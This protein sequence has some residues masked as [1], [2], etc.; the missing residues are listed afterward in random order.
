[1][2][3]ARL[4]ALSAAVALAPRLLT[5]PAFA[6]G[7]AS[8]VWTVGSFVPQQDPDLGS[9]ALTEA[10]TGSAWKLVPPQQP[11]NT[12]SVLDGVAVTSRADAWAVGNENIGRGTLIEH[13]NGS[14][15]SIADSP[16]VVG[17]LNTTGLGAVVAV[18]P[19]DVWAVGNNHGGF[20]TLVEHW[21]GS[22]WSL[23]PAP[24]PTQIQP[25]LASV[26]AVGPSDIWA[27]GSFGSPGGIIAYSTLAEHWDGTNWS[28]VPSPNESFSS[29]LTGVTAVSARDVWAVG[30]RQNIDGSVVGTLVEHWDGVRWSVIPS[31]SPRI[32]PTLNGVAAAARDDIWAVGG[33]T[34]DNGACIPLIEH[35]DGV[36]WTQT[37]APTNVGCL[38]GVHV[39]SSNDVWAVGSGP[40]GIDGGTILHW[41]GASWRVAPDPNV[42][43]LTAVG[44]PPAP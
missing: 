43:S 8:G 23:V 5:G 1:M 21:N 29:F 6:S 19:D 40:L 22:A 34:Q 41:N 26:A 10:L 18:S 24:D 2:R 31:P 7:P 17:S 30:F 9:H 36:R 39:V 13:W 37:Q 44:A 32:Q 3:T 27:V 20:G 33:R 12:Q 28:I 16:S 15:W 38:S 35:W 4:I 42:G 14:S 25:S 11:V